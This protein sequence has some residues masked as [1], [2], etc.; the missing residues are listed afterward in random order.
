MEFFIWDKVVA[1]Q[2]NLWER[3][4]SLGGAGAGGWVLMRYCGKE[5]WGK[6]R[7][8]DKEGDNGRMDHFPIWGTS[9]RIH[10][11]GQPDV[12]HSHQSFQ[13]KG[14][15]HPFAPL[16]DPL[17]IYFSFNIKCVYAYTHT[18]THTCIRTFSSFFP[19]E[20]AHLA[21]FCHGALALG[22]KT[23][24]ALP[25]EAWWVILSDVK[26]GGECYLHAAL[27]FKQQSERFLG[28]GGLCVHGWRANKCIRSYRRWPTLLS[29]VSRSIL[30][31][32][33]FLTSHPCADVFPCMCSSSRR[34]LG[35]MAVMS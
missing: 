35:F 19:A 27:M 3:E 34:L 5:G 6:G 13:I 29:W 14:P 2:M 1:A 18:H 32:E 31:R 10:H 21:C 11:L 17:S 9:G 24:P 22:C 15:P 26:R 16:S 23:L 8:G 28:S 20:M 4:V 33:N 30:R 12:R 7:G 25:G